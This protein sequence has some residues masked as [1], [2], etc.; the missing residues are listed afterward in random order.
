MADE[1][2]SPDQQIRMRCIEAAARNPAPHA[3][4]YAAGILASAKMFSTWVLEGDKP[5]EGVDSLL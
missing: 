2:N 3:D 1:R 4:G 5:A